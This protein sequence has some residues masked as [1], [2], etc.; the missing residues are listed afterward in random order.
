MPAPDVV[1]R[2]IKCGWPIFYQSK[3]SVPLES[4]HVDGSPRRRHAK[5]PPLE[6]RMK[7]R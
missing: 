7:G 3:N 5:C 1:D 2:C 6:Q 4:R